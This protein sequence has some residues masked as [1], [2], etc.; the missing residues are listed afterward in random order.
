M[1]ILQVMAGAEK[2]G[3][4]KFFDRL[5]IALSRRGLSQYV[6]C[7]AFSERLYHLRKHDIPFKN[8]SFHRLLD[9]QTRSIIHRA[10]KVF[11]P[12]IIMTWMSR[13]THLCPKGS[14]PIV[15]RLG[16]YYDLKYYKKAD[17][18]I[19]NTVGIQEYFIKKGWL[20]EKAKYLPN[21]VD[22]PESVEP[23]DKSV[24]LTP[25]NAPLL[26]SMGRFHDDKGFDILIPAL[27]HLPG[28]Y[29]WLVGEGERENRLRYL[30]HEY[31]V[32]ERIRFI[33][34]QKDVS[35][36]YKAADAYICPSRIEPLGNVVIEAWAHEI[37]VIAAESLGPKSLIKDQE[38]GL[39]VPINN[40]KALAGAIKR[41]LSSKSLGKQLSVQGLRTYDT[42]YTE[43]KV[44]QH[45]I[46]FFKQLCKEKEA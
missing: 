34:W 7:R 27:A 28:V 37:P 22:P 14:V 33:K 32:Q 31:S 2:G 46:N 16:G 18:L 35:P 29:L 19:G 9:F 41:L 24:Y 11:K 23:Q 36:L 12:D 10:I 30:A 45:Y 5:V 4:E 42:Y 20:P 8:A 21:F 44:C 40:V 17:Y 6:I 1:K 38:N 26:L 3:A 25:Q 15:A 43:E 39:L 13:A